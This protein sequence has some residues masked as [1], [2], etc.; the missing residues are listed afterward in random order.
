M[1]K[2]TKSLKFSS[3]SSFFYVFLAVAPS[4]AWNATPHE[5]KRAH[6]QNCGTLFLLPALVSMN[7]YAELHTLDAQRVSAWC[8]KPTSMPLA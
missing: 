8:R 4:V 6:I 2:L 1:S 3:A 5:G 7:T